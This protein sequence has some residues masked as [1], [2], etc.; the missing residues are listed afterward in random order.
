MPVL[1][2]FAYFTF[3][4]FQIQSDDYRCSD[5]TTF[6]PQVVVQVLNA[7]ETEVFYQQSNPKNCQVFPHY[8]AS[9]V[10]KGCKSGFVTY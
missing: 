5:K 7:S 2:Y 4:L 8:F 10:P 1:L 3:K 6:I 9:S